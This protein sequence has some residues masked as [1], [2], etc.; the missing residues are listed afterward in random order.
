MAL[1]I[2]VDDAVVVGESVYATR[3][4]DGDTIE[5]TIR[6]TLKVAIPTLFGVF[7]TVAA[8]A[9][10]SNI[11]GGLGNLYAQFGT[12]VTICLLLSVVESKLILPSHLAHLPT[13]RQATGRVAKTWASVQRGADNG[14]KWFTH[15]L[16]LPFLERAL[17]YRYAMILLFVAMFVLVIGMPMKGTV[18]VGFFPSMPGDTVSASMTLQSDASYG[19][20]ERN[21]QW[22]EATLNQADQQLA[23][24][25]QFDGSA[26]KSLHVLAASDQSGTITVELIK[27]KPYSLDELARTWR[28]LAG[29]PEGI[30]QLKI[31]S[32]REMVDAFKVELKSVSDETLLLAED[33]F[34]Q[35][36]ENTSGVTSVESSLT[37]GEAMMRF[38]LTPQ[39]RALGMDTASLSRQLLQA[40]GGDI[41][42]R[43]LRNKNEVKVRVRYPQENRSNPA[44]ILNARV[45]VSDGTV[46]PLSVVASI[47]QDSQQQQITRIDGLRALTVSASVDADMISAT[48]LVNVMNETL[49]PQLTRQHSDLTIHFA[50]E[51]EQQEETSSSMK[52]LTVIAL[53]AI[54]ALLA[55]PLKSYIQPLIIMS[56]IPF[57]IVGAILGHWSNGLMMSIL[58]MH[59]ILALSGVVVNDSLLL[60]SR[61]N[62]LTRM[63]ENAHDAIMDACSGRLRAILLTSFTTFAGLY[64]ILGETSKQAQFLI[65][66]AVSLGY[67]ILFATLITLVLI[68]ALVMINEDAKNVMTRVLA[69]LSGKVEVENHDQTVVS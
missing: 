4:R 61:F 64:P 19:Q 7:T 21:M 20:T 60:V 40:F 6:G 38:E 56:A 62:E 14:L 44:D 67:G 35:A 47:I 2:V 26:I 1:G 36:L 13:H 23:A 63:G 27:D 33:A 46:V 53:I 57:G 42:Q 18:R 8:F 54:Y 69:R 39:G 11:S 16:Y 43:Y 55:I 32:R 17:N 31:Q 10:L 37:P 66:A 24:E 41:V 45:R 58:S 52:T 29:T 3:Q 15:K 59:G 48:E 49:V 68:P 28:E 22:L 30:K 9:A 50:G 25:K 34:K 12:V 65:P 5:N 51:A